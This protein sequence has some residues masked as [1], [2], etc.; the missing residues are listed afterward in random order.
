M[1]GSPERGLPM[2]SPEEL[3]SLDRNYFS[4]I[5]ADEY[6]VT[7]MSRNT[8]H[9]WY[10]HNPEYPEKGTIILL[11]KHKAGDKYHLHGRGN[12]LGQVVRSIK[13]HDRFQL[14]G[15]KPVRR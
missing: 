10:L 4:V 14:N 3:Q 13:S 1:P 9:F 2:F 11:H 6:D 8:G 5:V 12:S 15:R 7:I